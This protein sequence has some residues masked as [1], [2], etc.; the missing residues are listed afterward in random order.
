MLSQG[1]REREKNDRGGTYLYKNP[2]RS[3]LA[4]RREEGGLTDSGRE[5]NQ[6]K[7]G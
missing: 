2:K 7:E 6:R 5:R 3:P 4:S 1:G